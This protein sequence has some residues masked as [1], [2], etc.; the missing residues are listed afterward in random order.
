M[1][2]SEGGSIPEEFQVEYVADRVETTAAVWMGTTLGCA[3]CH[4][5]KY[6]P[7]PQQGFL[8][9]LR[10]LQPSSRKAESTP[11][12]ETPRRFCGLVRRTSG[13]ELDR[14]NGRLAELEPKSRKP[15][16]RR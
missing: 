10:L 6:D 1:I 15:P 7:F 9:F 12:T 14:L 16:F 8:P 2:N 4:D 11:R 3:R 13:R 5:H